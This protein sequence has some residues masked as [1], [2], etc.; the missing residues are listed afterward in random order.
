MKS[1]DTINFGIISVKGGKGSNGSN[2]TKNEN[3]SNGSSGGSGGYG[4]VLIDN[5]YNFRNYGKIDKKIS[6]KNGYTLLL[7]NKLYRFRPNTYPCKVS[8]RN[9]LYHYIDTPMALSHN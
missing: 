1:N 7:S 9:K 3:D 4:G 5:C 8:L 2:D 6:I